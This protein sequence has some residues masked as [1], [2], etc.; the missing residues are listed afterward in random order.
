MVKISNE[1]EISKLNTN[2]IVNESRIK[3]LAT[4]IKEKFPNQDIGNY[5]FFADFIQGYL[6]DPL[7][8]IERSES[9]P[10]SSDK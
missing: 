4:E 9:K 5:L 10:E 6:M 8:F 3:K 2:I 7:N 1:R